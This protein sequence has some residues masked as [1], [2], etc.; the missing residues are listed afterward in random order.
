MDAPK[1][2]QSFALK[3]FKADYEKDFYVE[4]DVISILEEN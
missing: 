2:S 3:M 1:H 4:K